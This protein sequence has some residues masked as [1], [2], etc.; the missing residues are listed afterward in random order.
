MI[1]FD[2]KAWLSKH[3][4]PN[5]HIGILTAFFTAKGWASV[6]DVLEVLSSESG[7]SCCIVVGM[8]IGASG[9]L[10]SVAKSISEEDAEGVKRTIVKSLMQH[11]TSKANKKRMLEMVGETV[12]IRVAERS[13]HAK[14]FFV[15]NGRKRHALIG[16]SNF[17]ATGLSPSGQAEVCVELNPLDAHRA[18]MIFEREWGK[19]LPVTNNVRQ[20]LGGQGGAR[21]LYTKSRWFTGVDNVLERVLNE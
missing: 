5:S 13:S 16:S 17:T 1:I 12:A 11:R 2:T 14:V 9:N 6:L 19:A 8:Q 15:E 21:S 7:G 4:Q 10:A 20:F 3:V 18:T